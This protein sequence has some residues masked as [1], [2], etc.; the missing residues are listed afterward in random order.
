MWGLT[1][2]ELLIH[3]LLDCHVEVL[4][5]VVDAHNK[6]SQFLLLSSLIFGNIN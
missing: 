1:V 4:D 5:F 2:P 6:R 3:S